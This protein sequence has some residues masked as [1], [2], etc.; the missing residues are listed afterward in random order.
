MCANLDNESQLVIL[1]G[2]H[3]LLEREGVDYW[4]FGGWAV[5]LYVVE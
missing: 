1:G 2:L 5:D 3:E 4:V